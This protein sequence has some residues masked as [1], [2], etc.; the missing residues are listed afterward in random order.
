[1]RRITSG[2][3]VK[4][5]TPYTGENPEQRYIV[6]EVHY[7]E[8]PRAQIF[9]LRTGLTFPPV[10]L[11][12]PKE[13]E[14]VSLLTEDLIGSFQYIKTEESFMYGKV[15]SVERKEIFPDFTIEDDWVQTDVLIEIIA[16]VGVNQWGYLIIK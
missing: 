13:L 16:R 9:P 2:Q 10:N 14:V 3:I 5:H 4:F 11:A 6:L 15:I 8:M 1:M 7:D 12:R